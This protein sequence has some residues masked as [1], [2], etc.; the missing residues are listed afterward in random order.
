MRRL[1]LRILERG[2]DP[3]DRWRWVDIPQELFDLIVQDHVNNT[4]IYLPNL[5]GRKF[6]IF[7]EK[8][9]GEKLER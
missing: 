3:N 8:N 5:G 7:I 6:L 4:M 1:K 2:L 9:R